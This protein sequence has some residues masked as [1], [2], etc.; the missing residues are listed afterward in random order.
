MNKFGCGNRFL[1][2]L[3]PADLALIEPHLRSLDLHQG[4]C[5]FRAGD[6]IERVVFPHSGLVSL[7]ILLANGNA[8]ETAMIGREGLVGGSAGAGIF[9]AVNDACVQAPG[10][11][12]QVSSAQFHQ[13]V[14][15][16][17]TLRE[18]AARCDAMQMAQAHQSAACHA[19]HTVEERMCRWL[20]EIR[21]RSDSDRIPL[22]Q[23]FLAKMLGVRRTTVTLVAS[24][25]QASGAIKWRRGHVH[26]L[27]RDIL[28][29]VACE[30]YGRM[31]RC[32]DQLLA[33]PTEAADV[34][35]MPLE[36]RDPIHAPV[37]HRI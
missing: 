22:T 2:A 26:Y 16:S 23:E 19:T 6:E 3:G 17:V 28:E 14:M 12:V 31:R 8:V 24:K 11:A 30:C 27:R 20:L 9:Q 1:A 35:L 32:R 37:L 18:W 21:D 25:L 13:A 7:T 4:A 10:K 29:S 34:P 36:V 15:Q 5:L 33:E